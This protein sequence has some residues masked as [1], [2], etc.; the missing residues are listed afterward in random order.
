[1]N[2]DYYKYKKYKQLYKKQKVTVGGTNNCNDIIKSKNETF[3]AW[4]TRCRIN[5]LCVI[6]NKSRKCQV[7]PNNI[8]ININEMTG[9]SY[10]VMIN[11]PYTVAVLFRMLSQEK[12]RCKLF[13]V[14]AEEALPMDEDLEDGEVIFLLPK[15]P[16]TP[17]MDWTALR[18]L[19]KSWCQGGFTEDEELLETY[20]HISDWDVGNVTDMGVLFRGASSFNQPLN[21][22]DVSN[23]TNMSYMFVNASS[24]NQSLCSWNVSNV[25]NMEIMFHNSSSFNQPLN[26]W[27][28][29]NVTNMF[30]MFQDAS[31]FNQPLNSWRS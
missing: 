27:N 14:G 25:T 15:P 16:V 30:C 1:M 19:V 28:V 13:R 18:M 6:N 4:K 17:I 9:E 21:G 23:V 26:S 10:P 11:S 12:R 8:T 22:W 31:S 24:F 29:S 20:G 7:N 3:Q 5:Q 2:N